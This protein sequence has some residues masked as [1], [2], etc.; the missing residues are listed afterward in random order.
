MF[1]TITSS[2]PSSAQLEK[3]EAFLAQFLPRLEQEPGV[4]AIYHYSRPDIGDDTTIVIWED[5]E[6]VKTYRQ[7]ALIQEAIAF[8]KEHNL[9]ATR[10]GY[11][12]LYA[13]HQ[14]A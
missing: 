2:K 14:K 11:P 1:I 9:P 12:L 13:T 4:V 10:E 5:Q 8:E 3:A 6:A 7:S